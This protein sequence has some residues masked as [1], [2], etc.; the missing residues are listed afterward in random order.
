MPYQVH[1]PVFEGPFDL[2]LH[3]VTSSQVDIQ[4]V[5]LA[6]IVDGFVAEL[7]RR[8]GCDLEV[9]SEFLLIAAILVELKVRRL[10]PGA[11]DV[12][13]DEELALW[14]QR[15]LLLARLV[16][17]KTFKD[18]AGALSRLAAAA[19]RSAPRRAGLDERWADLVPD[20]LSGVSPARL[21]AAYL[22]AATP[23]PIPTVD[24]QHVAPIRVS[25]A[26]AVEELVGELPGLGP[27]TFRRL[28]GD[29]VER[30]AVIVRFLALLELCK[31]GLVDLDQPGGTFGDIEVV[32]VGARTDG[33]LVGVDAYDG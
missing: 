18:A 33:V 13:P 5:S 1:T 20:L 12:D 23:K 27:I 3:L 32:W 14:E 11:D 21:R 4:D 6:Q 29:L 10:L 31:Q 16:E 26:E 8:A 17:C 2:L 28:T 22:R 30:L 15:D 19:G 9:T 25:V 24:L 7:D